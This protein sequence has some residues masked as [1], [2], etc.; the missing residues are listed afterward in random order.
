MKE[1]PN[2][3]ILNERSNQIR[4]EEDTQLMLKDLNERPNREHLVMK[5]L[6]ERKYQENMILLDSHKNKFQEENKFQDENKFLDENKSSL[7]PPPFKPSS[8]LKGK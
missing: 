6:N 4:T 1:I 5:G 8:Q 2:E 3:D 7:T